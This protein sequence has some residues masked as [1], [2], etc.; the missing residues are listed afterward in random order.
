MAVLQILLTT[1]YIVGSAAFFTFVAYTL[2][3]PMFL[4]MLTAIAVSFGQLV[5]IVN[6]FR[7]V[8]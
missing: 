7:R 2:Q 4:V 6:A 3:L 5:F 1:A 8:R